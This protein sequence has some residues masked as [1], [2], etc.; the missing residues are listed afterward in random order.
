MPAPSDPRLQL[1][2][3]QQVLFEAL[4]DKRA[5]L[6][7]WYR[8]AIAVMNDDGL[9]DRLSLAAHALREIMEKLPGENVDRGA[10]LPSKVRDL[11]PPWERACQERR[12]DTWNGDVN[13]ALREFLV[14]MQAFFEGQ[15]VLVRTRREY[16]VEFLRRLDVAPTGLPDDVQKEN[17]KLWVEFHRYFDRIAHHGS[18]KEEVFRKQVSSLEAFLSARIMPRPTIDFA[19]IETLVEEE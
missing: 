8:A 6:G 19:R 7:E 1:A 18:V 15:A 14:V 12:G 3:T 4:V 11:R 2:P 5:P 9:P 13:D 10:D 16:A 17:A